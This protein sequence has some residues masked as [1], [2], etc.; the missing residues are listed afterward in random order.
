MF[1]YRSKFADK[2]TETL[3][4]VVPILVIVLVP[5]AMVWVPVF[6]S[7]PKVPDLTVAPASFTEY[8]LTT[9]V[10]AA[11]SAIYWSVQDNVLEVA[12]LALSVTVNLI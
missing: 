10:S 4:A 3:E 2:F 5:L 7:I 9:E 1:S 12:V 6:P 11:Y 8:D